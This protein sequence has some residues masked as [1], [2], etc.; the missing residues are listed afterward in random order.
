MQNKYRSKVQAAR[1][2][3]S[4]R[5]SPSSNRFRVVANVFSSG[6]WG[7]GGLVYPRAA[8]RPAAM[9]QR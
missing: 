6:F 4:G 8:N 7:S 2:R 9:I 5:G 3:P 1:V